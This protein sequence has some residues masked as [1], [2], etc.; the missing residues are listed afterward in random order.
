ML[1][2]SCKKIIHSQIDEDT[3]IQSDP[4]IQI[5]EHVH[6]G[7]PQYLH[8]N[9]NGFNNKIIQKFIPVKDNY[10]ERP[11]VYVIDKMTNKPT[12]YNFD[13]NPKVNLNLY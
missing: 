1:R 9:L 12:L 6:A 5:A 10:V 11:D 2:L 13:S 3:R 8:V 4:V 7:F